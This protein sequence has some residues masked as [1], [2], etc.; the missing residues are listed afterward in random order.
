VTDFFSPELLS[1]AEL[2]HRLGINKS[3]LAVWQ[4]RYTDFPSAASVDERG[5]Q[6]YR[7]ADMVRWLD[8]RRIPRNALNADEPYG[9]SYGRRLLRRTAA[10]AVQTVAAVE[11][12]PDT[13]A[14][15]DQLIDL[16]R[17]WWPPQR[18]SI[19][20]VLAALCLVFVRI[21]APRPWAEL[22]ASSVD[23]TWAETR[24]ELLQHLN[25]TA[26]RHG[27]AADL[28]PLLKEMRPERG[29]AHR[30]VLRAVD[31]LGRR[32]AAL[33]VQR[34]DEVATLGP[35]DYF[36]P[37]AI[38]RLMAGLVAHPAGNHTVIYDPCVRGG[39][40]LSAVADRLPPEHKVT[41]RG[42]GRQPPLL[43]IAALNLATTGR[44]ADLRLDAAGPEIRADL[45]EFADA[46]VTNPPF[47]GSRSEPEASI[48]QQRPSDAPPVSNGRYAWLLHSLRALRPGGTAAV[49]MPA[50]AG[51]SGD[52]SERELRQELLEQGA[53][54]AVVAL[55]EKLV[56]PT[57]VGVSVWLLQ[58]SKNEPG[59]VAFVDARN[60]GE[61]TR[62][63]RRRL[64]KAT[65]DAIVDRL[66]KPEDLSTEEPT[67]LVQG[68]TAILAPASRIS[69]NDFALDPSVY[70]Q[71]S[72]EPPRNAFL[73]IEEARDQAFAADRAVRKMTDLVEGIEL[74]PSSPTQRQRYRLGD[75]C[76]IQPGPSP[77]LVGKKQ[78][79]PRGIPIVVNKHLENGRIRL[80]D[81]QCLRDELR[82]PMQRFI[83]ETGDI[84]L[85]RT[86][87]PKN[88]VMV[89]EANRGQV[90]GPNLVRLRV[91]EPKDL[92]PHYLLAFLSSPRLS[93][94]MR[95][96]S[97]GSV[98][99][100]I[101][102]QTL[103]RL[104][105]VLPDLTEQK[106]VGAALR[107]Y[108]EQVAA[109]EDGLQAALQARAAVA[110]GLLNGSAS[111][112]TL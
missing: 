79:H 52:H 95:N 37:P 77:G 34:Y 31:R 61:P 55:P 17:R 13:P 86:G 54:R 11:E 14:G 8:Q 102:A 7:H 72:P 29:S 6:Y 101:A 96:N 20:I 78:L 10:F 87:A 30:D 106:A 16:L 12:R 42:T 89:T 62:E 39:E 25:T 76:E 67:T 26:R 27:I 75:L 59:P 109:Y 80:S 64:N 112:A 51:L 100:S 5:V 98:V 110:E 105:L 38:Q 1:R 73:T 46:V 94:W 50:R 43:R 111:L 24:S 97:S 33:L 44:S 69:P 18:P 103:A 63:G 65:V 66:R 36:T 49:L 48:Q 41:I 58:Y 85:V 28:S 74:R 93:Q 19:D 108:D 90:V 104:E 92:D 60:A 21:C 47:T 71:H 107:V 2:A 70:V 83:L 91:D 56:R 68:C 45:T 84:L 40:L 22:M 53:V 81:Y 57:D 15:V 3:N 82:E 32:A 99:H 4:G 23:E 9:S 35:H 88:P